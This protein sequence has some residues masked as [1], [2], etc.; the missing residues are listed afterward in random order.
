MR[1]GDMAKCEIAGI[2]ALSNPVVA[3]ST[4]STR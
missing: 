2:G 3:E 1:A 4:T